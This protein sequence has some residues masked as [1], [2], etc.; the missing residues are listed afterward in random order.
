MTMSPS[1]GSTAGVDLLLS[2]LEGVRKS[3][4][5]WIARCPAHT[6]KSPSLSIAESDDGKVLVHCF[7]G[8]SAYDV[9]TA[10]GLTLADLFPERLAPSSPAD[11]QRAR[12]AKKE[13]DWRAALNILGREST[14]ALAA[15]ETVLGGGTLA[16]ED[17]DRLKMAVHRIGRAREVFNAP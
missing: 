9:V 16:D 13:S 15:A 5:G 14:V 8:C 11:R 6:D 7:A 10:V 1:L 3:G 2:R 17:V 4:R 12:Q